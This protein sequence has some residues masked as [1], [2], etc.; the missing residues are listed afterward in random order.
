MKGIWVL[1]QMRY[2]SLIC[3]KEWLSDRPKYKRLLAN[4]GA[5]QTH[6]KLGYLYPGLIYTYL[7]ESFKIF[8]PHNAQDLLF[9][10]R[11]G[12]L[13]CSKKW[14][15]ERPNWRG[16]F[17]RLEGET[18]LDWCENMSCFSLSGCHMAVSQ[19]WAGYHT[20]FERG[21]SRLPADMKIR[22]VIQLIGILWSY[23]GTLRGL[24]MRLD[25]LTC[26]LVISHRNQ[27][28]HTSFD[29]GDKGLSANPNCL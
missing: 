14:L 5:F 25:C 26:H 7:S 15:S 29:R 16:M 23:F 1:F 19:S 20:S 6:P 11:Y 8:V 12:S 13:I 9:Q 3:S 22:T 18:V 24:P 28:Y 10:M 17:L 2:G 27:G 4:P 21:D